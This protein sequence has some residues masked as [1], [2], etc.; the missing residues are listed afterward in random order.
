VTVNL[1]FLKKLN[2]A[3]VSYNKISMMR[4]KTFFLEN[5]MEN[6]KLGTKEHTEL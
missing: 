1:D 5:G 6:L 4:E 2:Q 3:I